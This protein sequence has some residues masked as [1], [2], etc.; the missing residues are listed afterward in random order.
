[1]YIRKLLELLHQTSD[2]HISL[3]PK[4]ILNIINSY[5]NY[6]SDKDSPHEIFNYIRDKQRIA[7]KFESLSHYYIAMDIKI[8]IKE[9][10]YTQRYI[11]NTLQNEMISFNYE[12]IFFILTYN[13]GIYYLT[14]NTNPLSKRCEYPITFSI[15]AIDYNSQN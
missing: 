3:L 7:F 9:C 13:N 12:Y 15:K 10:S 4:D 8:A 5:F 14:A 2:S 1:M 6:V 11:H